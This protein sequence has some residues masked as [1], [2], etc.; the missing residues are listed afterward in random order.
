MKMR[1]ISEGSACVVLEGG[2]VKCAYQY[3]ALSALGKRF[4]SVENAVFELTGRELAGFAGSSFGALNSAVM[5]AYG[6]DGLEELWRAVSEDAVFRDPGVAGVLDGAF[7]RKLPRDMSSLACL[8]SLGIEPRGRM[9]DVSARYYEFVMSRVNERA[10][11]RS[12][13]E[14]GVTAVR[15]L[16]LEKPREGGGL[17]EFGLSETEHGLLPELVAASAAFPMLTPRRIGSKLFTDGGVLDNI[18][19][20]MME[21]RGFSAALVIRAGSSEPKKRWTDGMR[22]GFIAPSRPLGSAAAFSRDNVRDVI[23]LGEYD[24]MRARPFETGF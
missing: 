3:G 10:A 9:R 18:P 20:A 6:L 5:L 15:I 24:A 23:A 2:G 19:A 12:G 22:V 14:L 21:R 16:D 11:R 8:F 7:R 1:F 4:G 13:L 17:M